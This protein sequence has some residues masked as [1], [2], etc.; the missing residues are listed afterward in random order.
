FLRSQSLTPRHESGDALNAGSTDAF[1]QKVIIPEADKVRNVAIT[2]KFF[3]PC[4][5]LFPRPASLSHLARMA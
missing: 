5:K 1:A 3:P 2:D 4:A